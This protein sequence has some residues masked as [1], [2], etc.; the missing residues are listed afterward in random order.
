MTNQWIFST[1]TKQQEI[2]Q[3]EIADKLSISPILAKLLIERGI[4]TFEEARDFFCPDLSQLHDPFLIKDMDLAVKR[5]NKALANKES[6]LIYGDYDVDGTT[7]VALVYPF[8]PP[9]TSDLYFYISDR[10]N[11]W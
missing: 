3:K 6:I 9:Y 2:Y 5:L 4:T 8:P 7:A 10:Y 11:E 1:L